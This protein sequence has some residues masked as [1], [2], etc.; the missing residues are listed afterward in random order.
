MP[1][2][3]P[4]S[5]VGSLVTSH[6][7]PRHGADTILS[8][9][10]CRAA[11]AESEPR[12]HVW[13]PGAPAAA[14]AEGLRPSPPPRQ[15]GR[16]GVG[17]LQTHQGHRGRWPDPRP[18]LLPWDLAKVSP[19][20]CRAAQPPRGGQGPG[21]RRGG[22]RMGQRSGVTWLERRR[23]A[24]GGWQRASGHSGQSR[25]QPRRLP[26]HQFMPLSTQVQSGWERLQF[27]GRRELDSGPAFGKLEV[28][29]TRKMPQ[30]ELPAWEPCVGGHSREEQPG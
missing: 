29:G 30:G 3:R 22:G 7:W 8:R 24:W 19:E 1:E 11:P 2:A 10:P 15:A 27:A 4:G 6:T 20:P 28:P 14:E 18:G 17:T 12:L 13:L 25:G 5:C 21:G 23:P 26:F 9:G 16:T